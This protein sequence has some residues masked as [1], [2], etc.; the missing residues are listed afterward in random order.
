MALWTLALAWLALMAVRL[1]FL[2]FHFAN[3]DRLWY[4]FERRGL[5]FQLARGL[6]ALTLI[7][8]GAVAVRALWG[9]D[10]QTPDRLLR[11]FFAW[12]G[13][14]L[15]ERL[16]VHR[17]PRANVPGALGDAQVGLA[18]NLLLSFLGAATATLLAALY[19]HWRG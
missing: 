4:D 12:L 1:V 19:F 10:A 18:V 11:V 7:A 5:L 6:D 16:P 15:L 17:F 3:L 13:F 8:F 14:F 9:I 2:A